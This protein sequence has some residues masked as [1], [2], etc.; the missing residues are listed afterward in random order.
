[1]TTLTSA[2]RRGLPLLLA[3]FFAAT[4]IFGISARYSPGN[5]LIVVLL[6]LLISYALYG[7]AG[8][9]LRFGRAAGCGGAFLVALT[10][11][12]HFRE[13]TF[14]PGSIPEALLIAAVLAVP[15]YLLEV[16]L[17]EREAP[18]L[19]AFLL[20]ALGALVVLVSAY[21]ASPMLRWHL[22]RHNTMLGTPAYYLL[23][24][25][26]LSRQEALFDQHR[27]PAGVPPPPELSAPPAPAAQPNIVFVLL[28]TLRADALAVH[29]GD[30]DLMP[31]L[32]ELFADSYRFTN[33]VT[34]STWTR[35]SMASFF[36][37][38]LP[39]EHGARLMND[40]LA[41]SHTTLA[42]ILHDRGY[43]SA[44]F[45]ANVIA[46]G[47]HAGF[48]QGFETFQEIQGQPYARAKTVKRSVL[49][50]LSATSSSR[51]DAQQ[52]P[53][54]DKWLLYLHFF[55]PHEP[56]LSGEEPLFK[57]PESYLRAYA[58]ELKY[59][60]RELAEVLDALRRELPEPT[61]FFIT[62]DHGEEFLEHELFGH[63]FSLYDEVARIPAALYTGHGP[64]M[65]VGARLENRDFFDLLLS[66]TATGEF[67]IEEWAT[68]KAHDRR[69]TSLYHG[70]EGRLVLRPYLRNICMRAVEQD[71]YKL[72]WSA[73]GDTYELYDL[74]RDPGELWNLAA[75]EPERVA[76]MAATFD[77]HVGDWTFPETL[78]LTDE[79]LER[80]KTL[81]Y[82]N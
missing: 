72:I 65:D 78:E 6:Y 23:D 14:L 79:T 60:D 75:V 82:A 30:P 45:V 74:S 76:K 50:W 55:D 31:R 9:L 63:G 81:G 25:S 37:G 66:Y 10:A 20:P 57:R 26:I 17:F 53:S 13:Q 71:G 42:E 41:E 47:R 77:S 40:P 38:L 54:A 59:L 34:N 15:Y 62:S 4:A 33:V 52:D 58:E 19:R 39:E 8:W 24:R 56:Y 3:F 61:L 27:G 68:R 70:T 73:Y 36:T 48:D 80:L 49:R 46:G 29:G 43:R 32:N 69:Y 5:L 16:R 51:E 22:L 44:A 35:P 7:G 28:D 64:G 2:L 18:R 11:V 12:W 21:W 1:M 67:S